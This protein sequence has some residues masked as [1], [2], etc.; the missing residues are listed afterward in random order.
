MKTLI[1]LN[2]QIDGVKYMKN[3][4]NCNLCKGAETG[5]VETK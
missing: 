4:A 5:T 1:P 3:D 2:L